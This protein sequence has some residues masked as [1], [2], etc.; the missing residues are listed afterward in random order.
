MLDVGCGDGSFLLEA[1]RQ[2]WEVSGTEVNPRLARE[3]GLTIHEELVR[4]SPAGPYGCITLWH[5]LEHFRDPQAA[6][7]EAASLLAPDGVMLI[8][9]PNWSGAQARAFGAQWFHLDVPRHLFHF[10]AQS[11]SVLAGQCNLQ[12]R[13]TWHTEAELDLFGWTQ[14]ALNRVLDQ[15]NLLFSLVMGKPTRLSLAQKGVQLALGSVATLAALPL[16]S[17]S[18]ALGRGG[19]IVH[20]LRRRP[21]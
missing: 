5:S 9:V 2:G 14:S 15:P 3:R 12:V 18:V 13:Q 11:L 16:F 8:A 20:A 6:V 21:L 4:A 1:Q 10:S 19:I 17:T 7:Q